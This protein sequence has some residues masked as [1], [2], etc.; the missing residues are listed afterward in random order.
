MRP[1]LKLRGKP[2]AG[3]TLLSRPNASGASSTSSFESLAVRYSRFLLVTSWEILRVL[4][5]A[6]NRIFAS[7]ASS[8]AC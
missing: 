4:S 5:G 7:V 6:L 3:V 1:I 8:V 2:S